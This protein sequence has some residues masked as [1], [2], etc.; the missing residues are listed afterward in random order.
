VHNYQLT[1]Q[2]K[3]CCLHISYWKTQ[4]FKYALQF[5]LFVYINMELC[6]SS[7]GRTRTEDMC[8][9][10]LRTWGS[11]KLPVISRFNPKCR[12]CRS[13]FAH[14]HVRCVVITD[15]WIQIS[16]S[17]KTRKSAFL[18]VQKYPVQTSV[19]YDCCFI[20]ESLLFKYRICY[21]S[22]TYSQTQ[23]FKESQYL[24]VKCGILN[25]PQTYGPPRPLRG[26]ALPIFTFIV[27][28]QYFTHKE[29]DCSQVSWVDFNML[30]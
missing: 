19:T 15:C 14:S 28:K 16:D 18:T 13:Q 5:Y 29:H 25:I 23:I 12:Y 2:L 9:C 22:R 26:I 4:I 27:D 20:C 3:I 7:K 1:R 30:T 24:F 17:E 8:V 10:T 11:I 6:L 21:I